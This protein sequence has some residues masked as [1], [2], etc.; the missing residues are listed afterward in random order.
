M[1]ACSSA[2]GL[3]FRA[4][5]QDS[6]SDECRILTFHEGVEFI[7]IDR[8][9]IPLTCNEVKKRR[10]WLHFRVGM[11]GEYCWTVQRTLRG[12][13]QVTSDVAFQEM[14]VRC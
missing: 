9:E 14:E 3:Q 10:P 6:V 7:R 11:A 13:S 4:A 2:A 5:T 12:S 8:I 1:T